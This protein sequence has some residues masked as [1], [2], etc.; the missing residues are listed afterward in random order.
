MVQ[1]AGCH[2]DDTIVPTAR[3]QNPS[4]GRGEPGEGTN[5]TKGYLCQP[6]PHQ[7]NTKQVSFQKGALCHPAWLLCCR[8]AVSAVIRKD[9]YW[10]L[11]PPQSSRASY[12]P[13]LGHGALKPPD[14]PSVKR[15]SLGFPLLRSLLPAQPL[16][17]PPGDVS[18]PAHHPSGGAGRLTPTAPGLTR[19]VAQAR[20]TAPYSC[21][22]RAVA[23]KS[24]CFEGKERS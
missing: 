15:V 23:R 5:L 20:G 24:L 10:G 7:Q 6:K 8:T 18:P 19:R 2:R 3:C 12:H 9:E 17:S 1:T 14:S 13:C 21:F 4:R 22:I 11:P 16:C